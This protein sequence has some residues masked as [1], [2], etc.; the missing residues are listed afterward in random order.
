MYEPFGIINLE[1]M[2]CGAAVVASATGGI[3]EVVVEGETG[4][5]VEF[6]QDP[7]TSFPTEPARFAKDLATRLNELLADPARAKAMGQAGRRRVEAM[8]SWTIA[9]YRRLIGDQG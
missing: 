9:L 2:A 1:A 7:E 5:L 8:F 4:H 3:L 6:A